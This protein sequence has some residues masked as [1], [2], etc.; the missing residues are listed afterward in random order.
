MIPQSA[1]DRYIAAI[2]PLPETVRNCHAA[3]GRGDLVAAADAA[4]GDPAMLAYLRG[5]TRKSIYGFANEIKEPRQ[6]FGILGLSLARPVVENFMITL[7]SPPEF[8]VFHLNNGLFHAF[9]DELLHRWT[10]VLEHL[11]VEKSRGCGTLAPL[12]SS[13][14]LV[15]EGIFA[16]H[17]DQVEPLRAVHRIDYDLLLH[18]MTGMGLLDLSLL[19]GKKWEVAAEPLAVLEQLLKKEEG[20]EHEEMARWL[21]LLLFFVVSKPEYM[22]A[23]L[24]DFLELD[25]E[26]VQPLVEPFAQVME[27][28]ETGR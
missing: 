22:K 26:R 3:L 14:I 1:I 5:L 23:G 6:I 9:Q 15:C 27:A 25:T 4:V 19:I 8:K 7:L 28:Y 11:G 12:L 21:H 13:A 16:D 10:A 2:P 18:R 17:L 24:N 20:N